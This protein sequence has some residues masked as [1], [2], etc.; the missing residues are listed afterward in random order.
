MLCSTA[1]RHLMNWSNPSR[2][3]V[4]VDSTLQ[5]SVN[6]YYETNDEA[7]GEPDDIPLTQDEPQKA[8]RPT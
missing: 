8:E 2:L 7:Y 1:N 4:L 6:L 3:E 5:L